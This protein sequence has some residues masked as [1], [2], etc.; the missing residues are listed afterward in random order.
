MVDTE[1]KLIEVTGNYGRYWKEIFFNTF[2]LYPTRKE[3]GTNTNC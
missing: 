3:L 2:I 1:N